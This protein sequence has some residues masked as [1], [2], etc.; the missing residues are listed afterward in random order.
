MFKANTLNIAISQPSNTQY[1]DIT[2]PLT[3][4]VGSNF[5]SS[6]S[7]ASSSKDTCHDFELLNETLKQ[8]LNSNPNTS[9][10]ISHSRNQNSSER[11][12]NDQNRDCS[13]LLIMNKSGPPPLKKPH[14]ML[15]NSPRSHSMSPNSPRSQTPV[16][17]TSPP[18]S[19]FTPSSIPNMNKHQASTSRRPKGFAYS[20]HSL[21]K[22]ISHN[23]DDNDPNLSIDWQHNQM[24]PGQHIS[25]TNSSNPPY[26][27]PPSHL[28]YHINHNPLV[29]NILKPA[30]HPSFYTTNYPPMFQP[31]NPS[32]YLTS[33]PNHSNS[34]GN[35]IPMNQFFL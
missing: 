24:Q 2:Q 35:Y 27:R 4:Q 14:I 26:F 21:N 19:P 7:D 31:G 18:K 1:P 25:Y 9:G 13:N 10:Q 17:I 22:N 3:L 15:P 11:E 28:Q 5:D 16:L 20:S 29:S 30:F 33:L 6:N 32:N 8:K 34:T 12:R 23:R